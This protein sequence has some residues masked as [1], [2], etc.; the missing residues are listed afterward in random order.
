[1]LA[2]IY[3]I[4]EDIYPSP[5]HKGPNTTLKKCV[6]N[7]V[8]EKIYVRDKVKLTLKQKKSKIKKVFS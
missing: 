6:H 7:I 8:V 3:Y 5:F 1:M 2:T 4:Y